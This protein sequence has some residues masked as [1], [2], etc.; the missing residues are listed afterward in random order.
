M[1][2]LTDKRVDR[3]HAFGFQLSQGHMNGPLLGTEGA[4]AI[5]REIDAFADAHAGVAKQQ[6]HIAGEIMA[7]QYLLLDK[8]L[9]HR[10]QRACQPS[11]GREN[12]IR[13]EKAEQDRKILG[14]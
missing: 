8:R 14:P 1:D 3:H 7:S 13:I 12:V 11:I 5:E 2:E 9:L 4:K 6:E 10:S